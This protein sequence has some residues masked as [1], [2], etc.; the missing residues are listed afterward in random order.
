[1]IAPMKVVSGVVSVALMGAAMWLY[2]FKPHLQARMQTPLAAR[3]HIG[4]VVGNRVFS[5]KV[6]KVDVATAVTRQDVL[7]TP[8]PMPS[9]GIFVIVNAEIKSNEKPFQPGNVRLATRGGLS[10][11]ESGRTAIPTVSSD[12]QPML[13]GKAMFVFE[14][15]KDRLAGARLV[16]GEQ[17]LMLQLSAQADVD[18]GI[19]DGEA[20]QLLAH[21]SGSYVLK[22]T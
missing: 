9:L 14:I 15:P 18:L 16:V 2:T 3:G 11:D 5:V 22:T 4:A 13:W 17:Q 1:V 10:Y 12:F 7:S 19:D 20:K 6:D 21:A 8:K